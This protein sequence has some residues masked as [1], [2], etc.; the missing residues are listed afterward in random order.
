MMELHQHDGPEAFR[1]VLGGDLAGAAVEEL[2][3]AWATATSILK[4]KELIVDVSAVTDADAAGVD[5]LIRMRDTGARLIAAL[6]AVSRSLVRSLGITAA[7]PEHR[8]R[9]RFALQLASLV[10][11]KL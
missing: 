6:P 10:R 4:G 3:Q 11:L 1:F 8:S 2:A 9:S 5:L 7:T